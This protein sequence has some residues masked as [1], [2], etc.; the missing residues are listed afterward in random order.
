MGPISLPS[1]E[2]E[3]ELINNPKIQDHRARIT[4]NL[5]EKREY[6]APCQPTG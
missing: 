6:P 5:G 4:I 2:H 1:G 3:L